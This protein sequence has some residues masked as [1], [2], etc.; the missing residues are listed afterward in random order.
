M[1]LLVIFK[2]MF[3]HYKIDGVVMNSNDLFQTNGKYLRS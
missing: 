3:K 1:T 2:Q